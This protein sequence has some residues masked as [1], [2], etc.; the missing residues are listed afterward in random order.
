MN[1]G[2]VVVIQSRDG[3]EYRFTGTDGVTV[4]AVPPTGS[5]QSAGSNVLST[6][7]TRERRFLF[8]KLGSKKPAETA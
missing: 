8:S 3:K 4:I 6:P 5:S 7:K 2:R 1:R